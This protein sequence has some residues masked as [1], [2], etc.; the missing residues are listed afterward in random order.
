AEQALPSFDAYMPSARLLALRLAAEQPP[1]HEPALRYGREQAQ[2]R[3]TARMRMLDSA[4]A[5]IEVA[6]IVLDHD[7]LTQRAY[8][9]QLTGL[10][11][12]HAFSRYLER[13]RTVDGDHPIAVLMVD[14]DHFKDVNDVHG[15]AVGDRVL[16]GIA[17]SL[18]EGARATDLVA[19]LGGDEFLVLFDAIELASAVSRARQLLQRIGGRPWGEVA[20]GLI[21]SVSIGLSAGAAR[22]VD[23]LIDA[24]D[25]QLYQVKKSARGGVGHARPAGVE[26]HEA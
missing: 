23:D 18:T 25:R 20:D 22:D 26:P 8:V 13:L 4:R 19:R 5:R 1:T 3:W 9:D 16:R 6:R 24:A 11:N 7:R 14:V 17:G 10:A 21:V 2:A 12:R 15:H